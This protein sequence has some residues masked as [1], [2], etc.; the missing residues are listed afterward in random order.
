MDSKSYKYISHEMSQQNSFN[1]EDQFS[2]SDIGTT[3]QEPLLSVQAQHKPAGS[4]RSLNEDGRSRV[5]FSVGTSSI[6]GSVTFQ[7]SLSSH[8]VVTPS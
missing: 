1:L 6:H 3:E 5:H 4:A 2:L 7:C 8:A